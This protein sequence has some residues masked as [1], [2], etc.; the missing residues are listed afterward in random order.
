MGGIKMSISDIAAAAVGL[1]QKITFLTGDWEASAILA[2][3][4]NF[5][6]GLNLGTLADVVNGLL[7]MQIL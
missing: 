4:K 5:L 3:V 1:A 7:G 6:S 2:L